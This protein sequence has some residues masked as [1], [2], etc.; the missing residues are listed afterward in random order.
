MTNDNKD[1]N[2]NSIL[3]AKSDNGRILLENFSYVGDENLFQ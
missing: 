1:D 2:N 3:L